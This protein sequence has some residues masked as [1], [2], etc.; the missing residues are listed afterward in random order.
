LR[1]C[2]FRYDGS[3]L[4]IL[5]ESFLG[6]GHPA[7]EKTGRHILTDAYPTEPVALANHEVPLRLID[8]RTD[9]DRTLATI[10]TLGPKN[11]GVLRLD[12]HP[13]WGRDGRK[14]CFNGAPDGRR[15]IFIAHMEGLLS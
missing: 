13:A 3:D 5:S 12:P 7:F 11:P 10:F 15:Q 1:F 6:S 14:A 2:L 8:T 4:R 9:R